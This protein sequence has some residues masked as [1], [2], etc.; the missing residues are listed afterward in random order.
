MRRHASFDCDPLVGR[1]GVSVIVGDGGLVEVAVGVAEGCGV[2]VAVAVIGISVLVGVHVGDGEGGLTVV[3]EVLVGSIGVM[4][5]VGGV[6]GVG[7]TVCVGVL[8]AVT[9]GVNVG[10]QFISPPLSM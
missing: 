8:V 2:F 4:V 9:D 10:L 3:V 1:S 7:K 6:S 5:A